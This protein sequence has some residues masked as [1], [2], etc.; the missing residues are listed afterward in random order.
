MSIG[1]IERISAGQLFWMVGV[2]VVAGGVYIWPETV[3]RVAGFDALWALLAAIALA[4]LVLALDLTWAARVPGLTYLDRLRRLWGPFAWFWFLGTTLIML[5]ID[6]A[7]GA[8][9]AQMLQVFFYPNTPTWALLVLL[10][11]LGTWFGSQSLTTVARNTQFW[12][13][14]V[15]V[16]FFVLAWM[17]LPLAHE[18]GALT[19]YWPPTVHDLTTGIVATWY[20]WAQGPVAI[21]LAPWVRGAT[22]R[23]VRRWSL[24]ALVFQGT[25]LLIIGALV[26]ATLGP[27]ASR[28]LQWPLIYVFTN[29][30]P[31]AFFIARPGIFLLSTWSA[32]LVFYVAVRLFS[33]SVNLEAGFSLDPTLRRYLVLGL[34]VMLVLFG[35]T[36]PN[37][38]AVS[39]FL[40]G[41]VDPVAVLWLGAHAVLACLVAVVRGYRKPVASGLGTGPLPGVRDA[42]PAADGHGPVASATRRGQQTD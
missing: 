36:F 16:S 35:L 20:L 18:S 11:G 4:T 7:L 10:I 24:A 23:Q 1:P 17:G 33:A 31:V 6:G 3:L 8:L 15:L 32:A 12:F 22:W 27:W 42:V 37:P 39:R 9:F 25:M 21:T 26:V 40:V 29:L 34:G 2:T 38:G 5:A 30:G 13:P 28:I 14:I 19:P 41:T